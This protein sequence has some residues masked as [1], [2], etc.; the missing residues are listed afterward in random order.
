MADVTKKNDKKKTRPDL[1][2]WENLPEVER[3]K[4]VMTALAVKTALDLWKV[5]TT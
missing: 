3:N 5:L 2:P 4:Y 1:L